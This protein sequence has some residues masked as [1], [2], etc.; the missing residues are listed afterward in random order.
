MLLANELR[1][2]GSGDRVIR[3]ISTR[4]SQA[5]ALRDYSAGKA[6]LLSERLANVLHL[7]AGDVLRFPTPKGEQTFPV[8]GVFY[9]YNPNA[10]F[11]LQRGVYQRLWSDNQIDGIALYLK[12]TSGEQLKEQLF[13]RFGAKYALTVLPNGE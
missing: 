12:G 9:D 13:A 8:A 6:V 5:D 1:S 3:W 11:Y 7:R 4:G 10:V 2:F